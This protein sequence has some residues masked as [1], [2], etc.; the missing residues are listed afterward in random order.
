MSVSTPNY[1]YVFDFERDFEHSEVKPWMVENWLRV[2]SWAAGLYLTLIFGGQ[3]AMSG[4]PR[5]ELPWLLPAWNVF[6]ASFSIMGALRTLPE[7]LHA[8]STGG[9]YNSVCVPR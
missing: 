7:F 9:I 8:L 4:R 3:Y 1:S 2:C 6:L 5:F